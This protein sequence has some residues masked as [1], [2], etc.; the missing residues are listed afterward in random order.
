VRLASM[1]CAPSPRALRL[2]LWDLMR[3]SAPRAF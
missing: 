2:T 3:I 1:I